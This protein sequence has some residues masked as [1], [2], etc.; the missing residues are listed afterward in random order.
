[1]GKYLN[2]YSPAAAWT[3]RRAS[4]RR[5]VG[6]GGDRQRRPL[7]RLQ[8]AGQDRSTG[9]PQVVRYG[10]R[11]SD[12]A[13]DVISRHGRRF[14]ADAVRD[15]VPF[16]L[17][18]SAFAP[19]Y[20][21]T[22]APRDADKFPDAQAPRGPL[23]NAP[24]LEGAPVLA[25]EGPA[26]AAADRRARQR[27]PPRAQSVQAVDRMIGAVRAQLRRLGVAENTYIVFSSDNGFHTGQ[28]RLRP[29]KQTF[30]D[31]DIRVPLV[32]I[33]PGVPAA[34]LG[35]AARGQR[36]PAADLPG[37]GRRADRRPRRGPQPRGRSCCGQPPASW[38]NVTLIEHRGPNWADGDPDRQRARQGNPPSYNALRFTGRAVRRVRGRE[39]AGV[40]RPGERPV[41]A[42]Q[43]LRVAERRAAGRAVG[44]ARAD[45]RVQRRAVLPRRRS[46][47]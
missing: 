8:P 47:G 46:G 3:A 42:A 35:H 27:V 33:G 22:P 30:W 16:M 5:L 6:V 37:A 32:V 25:G 26:R 12:Y 19:H 14:I 9:R 41:R 45:A 10:S 43:R 15:G 31:H 28:R 1:M 18:L 36:R 2:G 24:Q 44:A 4:C 13:T 23:F 38:R 17:E 11:P 29:G 39:P 20:P 7:L 21:Y 40:L 34:R